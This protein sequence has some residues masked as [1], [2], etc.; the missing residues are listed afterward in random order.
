MN[1]G[2][3]VFA[4]LISFFSHNEFNRCVARYDGNKNVRSFSCWDQLLTMAFAQLT[5]RESLRD[6]EVCLRAQRGK[7]YHSGLA[8]PS[9]AIHVGRCQRDARLENL[10]RFRSEPDSD[11]APALRGRGTGNRPRRD[12][13]CIGLHNNRSLPFSVPMGSVS[14][15]Q[16]CNQASHFDRRFK[17]QS[18][19]LSAITSGQSTRYQS[20]RC[21]HSRTWLIHDVHRGYIDFARLYRIQLLCF[22]RN[23]FQRQSSIQPSI[24]PCTRPYDRSAKRS[25]HCVDWSKKLYCSIPSSFAESAITRWTSIEDSSS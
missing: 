7:L 17:A 3:T 5:Y 18:L 15:S 2:R 4:Q 12:I 16:S 21:D 22:L 6:I 24:L 25:D 9:Q 8:G 20:A 11:R 1:Q 10:C 13:V 19:Y 14:K 23:P